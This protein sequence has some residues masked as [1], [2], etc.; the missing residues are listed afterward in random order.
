[1][2]ILVVVLDGVFLM[3]FESE[4]LELFVGGEV[5]VEGWMIVVFNVMLYVFIIVGLFIV[6]C[7]YKL[8][9]GECLLCDFLCNMFSWCEV[10]VY[11]VL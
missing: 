8:V 6:H 9:V 10:V 1:V 11:C 7:I 3:L 4:V 2:V 5:M